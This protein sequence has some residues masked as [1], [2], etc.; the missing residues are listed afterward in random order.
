MSRPRPN[1]FLIGSMKSGTTHL[2]ALLADHPAVFMSSPKEPCHF[3]DGKT[4]RK[5]W[6][7]M[8]RRGFWK[9]AELYLSL[10]AGAGDARVIGEAEVRIEQ[11]SMAGH[12]RAKRRTA[13][14]TGSHSGAA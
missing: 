2:S 5:I 10:F 4:L 3:V 8:W 11:S 9:S 12:R 6:P 14:R 1:P 13:N 7:Y